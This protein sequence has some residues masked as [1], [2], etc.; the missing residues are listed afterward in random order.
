MKTF[1][2]HATY[3]SKTKM[4]KKLINKHEMWAYLL[5]TYGNKEAYDWHR[6]FCFA[7][8]RY[9]QEVF[10]VSLN[11]LLNMKKGLVRGHFSP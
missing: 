3:I 4:K 7:T 10:T 2:S 5:R 1:H 6:M 9:H 11:Y 8:D